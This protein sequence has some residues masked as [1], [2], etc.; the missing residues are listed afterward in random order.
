M[1]ILNSKEWAF[2]GKVKVKDIIKTFKSLQ[3]ILEYHYTEDSE[4]VFEVFVLNGKPKHSSNFD[5]HESANLTNT[6]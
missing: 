1:E 4:V 3:K 6:K 5:E 2:H